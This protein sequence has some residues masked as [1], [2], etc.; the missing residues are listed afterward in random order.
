[1]KQTAADSVDAKTSKDDFMRRKF[2]KDDNDDV[3]II[4]PAK[5]VLLLLWMSGGL[6]YI[7]IYEVR[8][9]F[10]IIYPTHVNKIYGLNLAFDPIVCG[11]Q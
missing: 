5:Q 9:F 10:G 2:R 7:D 6:S 4:R 1:M 8:T 11:R 3:E